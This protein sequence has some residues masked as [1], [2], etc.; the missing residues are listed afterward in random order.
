MPT[1]LARNALEKRGL[2]PS[3]LPVVSSDATFAGNSVPDPAFSQAFCWR[4]MKTLRL[5]VSIKGI[6][7]ENDA[8][9]LRK[10]ERDEWELP[11][12]K[13]EAGEQPEETVVRELQEELGFRLEVGSLVQAHV[14]AI[15]TRKVLVVSYLCDL[16]GKSGSFESIGEAGIAVFEKFPIEK[17]ESLAMPEFYKEAIRK[18]FQ[19]LRQR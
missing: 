4:E 8:V 1:S 6:V 16:I 15:R 3:L 11:G 5:P 10:N 2:A 12:G 14:H 17:I 19:M 13:L 7:F 9:W 18:G